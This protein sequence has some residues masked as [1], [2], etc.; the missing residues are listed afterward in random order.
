M[1]HIHWY[2]GH[3]AKAQKQLKEKLNLVDVIIEV[4]DA[5]IPYSSW[6]KTTDELCGA[7]PRLILMNK[8]D[9]SDP[10]LNKQ[11]ANAI[12]KKANCDILITNLSNKNDI[13][14]IISKIIKL[15]QDMLEKRAQK[16]LLPRPTR[17]MVIGMPNV[18][19]SSTINRLVKRAKT[20]TGA[21]AGVTRQQQWVRINDKIELLDTPG[22]IPTVQDDQFQALKLACVNSIGENA[23]D[24]E[25]VASELLKILNKKYRI[26]L[27]Q[28]YG[29]KKDDNITVES[30]AIKKGWILK[31]AQADIK[32]ASQIILS[33]F[34][35]GK[36]GKFT[37]ENIE[38]YDLV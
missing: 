17:T 28:Y 32:R 23:Y 34:R 38:E 15:S 3:I 8:S 13:N 20:K 26:N 35:E 37:L 5:R 16:G 25:Y 24:S 10:E 6:Y 18:G 30:I 27:E 14:I 36:I 1:S 33:T 9:V 4:I 31:G 2:P 12:S 29:F 11:W 7:K 21:K 22:I 19:K